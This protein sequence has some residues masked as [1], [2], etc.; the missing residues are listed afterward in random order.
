[1]KKI[2]IIEPGVKNHSVML[3][4]WLSIAKC[5]NWYL[6]IY[7]TKE[8]F[9]LVASS[10]EGF[11]Q[12]Y[13]VRL[14]KFEKDL[15]G[16]FSLFR[17]S[18]SS[19]VLVV[20]S[21]YKSYLIIYFLTL[22]YRFSFIY[23][24]NANKWSCFS[25]LPNKSLLSFLAFKVRRLIIR[26]CT[27]VFVSSSNMKSYLS[28]K[29]NS[30]DVVVL[31]FSFRRDRNLPSTKRKFIVYPGVVSPLRKRY[32]GFLRLAKANPDLD[33][34]LLGRIDDNSEILK[35]IRTEKIENITVF[36]SYIDNDIYEYYMSNSALMFSDIIV[37]YQGESYGQ[38]K[39]SGISYLSINFNVP[40]LVNREFIN[41]DELDKYTYYFSSSDEMLLLFESLKNND[42]KNS[43]IDQDR[44]KDFTDV[45]VSQRFK[46]YF[47]CL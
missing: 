34:V 29:D 43:E 45:V 26:A 22:L 30:L 14:I 4:N 19:E 39:D 9:E 24:H 18:R 31:P 13:D 37:D 21:V 35:S 6:K 41:L 20:N 38:T 46:R 27:G 42:F 3:I 11:E 10:F 2:V 32:D 17:Y 28:T 16:W 15:L 25:K 40:L 36:S 44:F 1:M 23:V 47:D 33:F 12:Y 5:N 8:C 7:T